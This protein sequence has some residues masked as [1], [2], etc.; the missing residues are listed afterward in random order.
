MIWASSM[1]FI[2]DKRISSTIS[3]LERGR[4]ERTCLQRERHTIT[5]FEKERHGITCL[6]G[7]ESTPSASTL[8]NSSRNLSEPASLFTLGWLLQG[9]LAHKKQRPPRTLQYDYA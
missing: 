6:K 4:S 9:Y 3:G 5:C 1:Y 8:S 7:R 2:N